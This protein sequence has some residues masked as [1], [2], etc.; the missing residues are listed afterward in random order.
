MIHKE[1]C[2]N[3]KDEIKMTFFDNSD[4]ALQIHTGV[5]L[6]MFRKLSI[7]MMP[8]KRYLYVKCVTSICKQVVE[9]NFS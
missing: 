6:N 2:Y 8:M 1:H 7:N 4:A 3:E 5:L 9:V